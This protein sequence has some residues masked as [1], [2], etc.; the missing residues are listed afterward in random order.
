MEPKRILIADDSPTVRMALTRVL[1]KAGYDVAGVA[2]GGEAVNRLQSERFD[3]LLLDVEMPVMNGFEVLKLIREN[4]VKNPAPVL[5]VTGA[6]K[7]LGEVHELRGLGAQGYVDK[8][9]AEA[10]LLFRIQRVF[11]GIDDTL[12]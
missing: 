3:L 5:V 1:Q 10:E 6:R 12:A 8:G 4:K 9:M 11:Q 7:S 2:D